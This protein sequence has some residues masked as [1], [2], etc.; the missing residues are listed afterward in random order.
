MKN[1]KENEYLKYNLCVSLLGAIVLFVFVKLDT[2]FA[3]WDYLL[4]T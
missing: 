2:L 4:G 3:S 1:Q